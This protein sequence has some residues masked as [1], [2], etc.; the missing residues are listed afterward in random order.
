MKGEINGAESERERAQ[1]LLRYDVGGASS[2]SFCNLR[3]RSLTSHPKETDRLKT[4]DSGTRREG[5]REGGSPE[6]RK[7]GRKGGGGGGGEGRR[8]P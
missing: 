6:G 8:Y 3:L 1:L 7:A 4:E 2:S 5:G